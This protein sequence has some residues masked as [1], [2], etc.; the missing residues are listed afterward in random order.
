MGT[1]VCKKC[2]TKKDVDQFRLKKDKCGKY[3]IYSYCK[4]CEKEYYGVLR[5]KYDKK[6][7]DTHR[8]SIKQKQKLLRDKK[9]YTEKEKQKEYLQAY[10]PS[11]RI[12]N[13]EKIKKYYMK[14]NKK[15]R[16]NKFLNFK[17]RIRKTVYRSFKSKGLSKEMHT[18]EIVGIKAKDLYIYLLQTFK[19]NY[20]IEWDGVENVHID[21]KKPLSI[22]KTEE[23]VIQLCHYTNLQL[24][25]A[26]DNLAKYN[27]LNWELRK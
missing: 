2:N 9:T 17:D 16:E 23:E 7:R 8:E 25:K 3:Y 14:D 24:L 13:A 27:K 12:K 20:G 21:H 5:K 1:K 4:Q 10:I 22:A 26:K 15:R 19:D 11:W 6:Y 18:Q